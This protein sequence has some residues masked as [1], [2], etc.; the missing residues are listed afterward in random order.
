TSTATGTPTGTAATATPTSTGTP[1][2][3]AAGTATSTATPTG[4]VSAT[5]TSTA[6]VGPP[7]AT[8]T[9]TRS[10]STP[11]GTR[12]RTA[13]NAPL[14]IVASI[15]VGSATG[16]P[17]TGVLFNVTLDTEANVA[18]T[19]ND[20]AFQP[21][22]RIRS[23]DGGEPDCAVNPAIDKGD[24]TFAFLPDGCTPGVDCTS[25]RALILSFGNLNP[26]PSGSIL[27]SCE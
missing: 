8:V 19:Q 24:S 16:Q 4:T 11:T 10:P 22:A 2:G 5:V 6:T 21:Q 13:T 27:Y 14:P 9:D 17:G 12:T 26:I 1:T 23:K 25:V 18:G 3:T 15:I 20:V 7:T